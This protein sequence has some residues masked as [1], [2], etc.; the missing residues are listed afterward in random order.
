MFAHLRKRV[1]P[2][3]NFTILRDFVKYST[4]SKSLRNFPLVPE[5]LL[6]LPGVQWEEPSEMDRETVE[7]GQLGHPCGQMI[8]VGGRCRWGHPQAL[9]FAPLGEMR[10]QDSTVKAVR[11][12]HG[13]FR[14]SCPMLQ[15]EVKQ[16]EQSGELVQM[17]KKVNEDPALGARLK[18]AHAS[19]P[20][21]RERL[22]PQEW[23]RRLNDPKLNFSQHKISEK[24]P[25]ILFQTGLVGVTL[26]KGATNEVK[27]LHAHLGDFLMRGEKSNPIGPLVVQLLEERGINSKGSETCWT[28]CEPKQSG[29]HEHS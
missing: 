6:A 18:A 9:M 17:Q 21:L 5:P 15:R 1:D 10:D 12:D 26:N 11:A 4:A 28:E 24:A 3:D 22:I 13:I 8:G 23:V 2:Y 19:V 29:S 27:C 16:M 7:K 20:G 14:L 25:M